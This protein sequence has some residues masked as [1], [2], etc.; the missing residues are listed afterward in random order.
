MA[1]HYPAP[2]QTIDPLELTINSH[3][4]RII[5]KVNARRFEILT[6]LREKRE[7]SRARDTQREE[8]ISEI[9]A[10]KSQV[11]SGLKENP[12]KQMQQKMINE[13]EKELG[14]LKMTPQ[15][16]E[17]QFSIDSI[18][19]EQAIEEIGKI[20]EVVRVNYDAFQPVVTVAKKG[21]GPGELDGP[22]GVAVEER[23][24]NIFVAEFS[25]SRVSVFSQT[26]EYIKSFGTELFKNPWG[27]A[28]QNDNLYV[29]DV[30]HK[31][32]YFKIPDMKLMQQVGK[33]GS[34]NLEFNCPSQLF[35]SQVGD[36]YV[37]DEFNN[38]IHVL[39]SKLKFK[40]I[41]KHDSMTRPVDIK[42]TEELMYV[43]SRADNPCFHVFTLT[44]DKIRSILSRGEN[45]QLIKPWFFC[46]DM[47][48]NIVV[49]DCGDHSIKIFTP[50]GEFLYRIGRQG[51]E[52]G[53]LSN[54][55][56]ICFTK[57]WSL[58]YVSNNKNFGLQIFS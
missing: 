28:I 6:E 55:S 53:M 24:G 37:C 58:I 40:I 50:E 44:G 42:L 46:I 36:V 54:P 14:K 23:S 10:M 39:N 15:K 4:D 34:G 57:E 26:G 7:E 22:E 35:I 31:V 51:L 11:E 47:N 56:G 9:A 1:E 17:L 52:K 29:S 18:S 45:L 41:L 33:K 2:S 25:N 19:V 13:M 12:L 5:G 30:N 21:S 16:K 20:S 48:A 27:I 32:F 8:M 3:F 38:R 43:L 49:S